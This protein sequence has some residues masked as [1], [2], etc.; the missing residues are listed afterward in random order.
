ML[1]FSIPGEPVPWA[2]PRLSHW[3]G[4]RYCATLHG[5]VTEDVADHTAIIRLYANAA[6]RGKP[7]FPLQGPILL[8]VAIYRTRPKKENKAVPSQRPDF[9]NYWK[10]I[11]DALEGPIYLDDSQVIG[12]LGYPQSGKFFADDR[13]ARTEITVLPLTELPGGLE[14]R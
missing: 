1:S 11:A 9:D 10:L 13:G 8:G 2:R 3:R 12:P 4:R 7:E 14:L 5:Y 6:V